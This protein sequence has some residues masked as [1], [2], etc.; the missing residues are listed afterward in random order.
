MFG[1]AMTKHHGVLVVLWE[2]ALTVTCLKPGVELWRVARG[3]GRDPGAP[4]DPKSAM[5]A[6]KVIERVC[7]SIPG[8]IL[9]AV[10]LLEHV[11]ARSA[12]GLASVIVAC[13]AT[14]F[15][16][17]TIAYNYDTDAEGRRTQS[18]FYG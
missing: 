18:A 2:V 7:E 16:A 10:T 13:V 17:T 14:A 3:E 5:L 15:V 6:G 9:T 11:D 12:W 4:L 8:A 1:I